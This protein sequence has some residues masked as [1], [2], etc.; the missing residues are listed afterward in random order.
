MYEKITPPAM[1]DRITFKDGEPI[2]PDHPIVPYIRGD[3]T[4][5][6]LWPASQRVF[7]AAVQA[8]YGGQR[9]INW[10]KVYAGDEACEQYGTYQYLPEDTLTAIREYGVAI[11]GPLTTPIGGGIRSLNVALRQIHDLYAC[12]RPCKY[13][14][15]TP[16][17]HRYPEKL[18]VI[19]YR[20]NTEDIYLG[21]EWKQGSAIA[22]RLIQLLNTDLIPGTPEHGKKQI[23]LDSG[24]GI[25][26]IS[27][28][29]SQRLVRRAIRH[30]LRLP[31]AKQMVTLVHKGNIMKYT[32]GA[33]RD[34]GY[35]LATTEFRE[36][37]V[38]E[39]ESWILSNRERTP[40]LAIAENAR[41]IEPG[42]DALTPEK[43]AQICQEVESVLNTIWET[44]GNGQW[45]DKIMVNDRIADSI[46]QQIQTRPDEYSILATMNLNGDYLSDAA[47]AIVGGLGM[48]PG[49]NIGDNCAIFEATHGTA[50]KH[51]GLD[52]VN[53]G[54]LILSGVM[55][56]EYMGWQEAADLIKK[57]LGAAIANREVT[58]DLARL[59]EPPVEPPL[60]CSEFAD[61]IIRYFGA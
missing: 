40:D 47:A 48:G 54:S 55:M 12:V 50:P 10:F 52:R 23:P 8:A 30:A 28:T 11:K 2:V 18:D 49:A 21:I 51:A 1:G 39:R 17:P 7:D 58:Y 22:D 41:K 24:I 57:G 45:K 20:E 9:Q 5:I 32:E 44:H 27:K 31:P 59:M 37:C 26:P 16:S 4:G 36:E 56:L 60:K 33:F 53:P 34:W 61:A 6:D 3:G 38:T 13:Y 25:K 15:G 46:F 43:Q 14:D 35:E 42:Y 29:G 19:I